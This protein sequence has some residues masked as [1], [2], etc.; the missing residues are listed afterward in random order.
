VQVNALLPL[1]VNDS[2]GEILTMCELL[3]GMCVCVTQ[4]QPKG[5]ERQILENIVHSAATSQLDACS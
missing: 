4:H 2:P 3:S 1:Q 5:N